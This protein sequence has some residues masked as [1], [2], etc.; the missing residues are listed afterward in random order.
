MIKWRMRGM[1]R[2]STNISMLKM[3][4]IRPQVLNNTRSHIKVRKEGLKEVIIEIEGP[5]HMD[6]L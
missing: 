2:Q 5:N 4:T 3:K 6:V 1:L